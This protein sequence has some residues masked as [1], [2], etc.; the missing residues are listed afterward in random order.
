MCITISD[1]MQQY[2]YVYGKPSETIFHDI[3]CESDAWILVHYANDRINKGSICR[4]DG[5]VVMILG[6]K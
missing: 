6:Y 4:K 2:I 3:V 5:T 1:I